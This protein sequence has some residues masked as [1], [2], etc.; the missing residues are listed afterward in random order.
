M[1]RLKA[2]LFSINGDGT[3]LEQAVHTLHISHFTYRT[4]AISL[5][6][7]E[8]KI[9]FLNSEYILLFRG[10]SP[11]CYSVISATVRTS[12][13]TA[14]KSGRNNVTVHFY[15]QWGAMSFPYSNYRSMREQKPYP[16]WFSCRRKTYPA[17][18]EYRQTLSSQHNIPQNQPFYLWSLLAEYSL[19]S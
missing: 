4:G 11:S 7:L 17:Y 15:D 6:G 10:S 19:M 8:Y 14:T 3:E 18:C 12:V 16:I 5:E 2:L 1:S 9:P 13:C